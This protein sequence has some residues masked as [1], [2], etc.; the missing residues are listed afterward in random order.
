MIKM[1][2]PQGALRSLRRFSTLARGS[3]PPGLAKPREWAANQHASGHGTTQ[4]RRYREADYHHPRVT[5]K[6]DTINEYRQ[7]NQ[8]IEQHNIHERI[9]PTV[10]AVLGFGGLIPFVSS[11]G[12]ILAAHVSPANVPDALS[13]FALTAHITYGSVILSFL[14]AVHWGL[15]LRSP[16]LS[17]GT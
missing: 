3:S 2:L 17:A 5:R 12:V 7:F 9:I 10:P 13:A 14:G 1:Q 4:I 16:G 11:A 15:A 6:L 8:W